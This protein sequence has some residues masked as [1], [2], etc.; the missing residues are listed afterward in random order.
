MHEGTFII[1]IQRTY[2]AA[3][4]A[5]FTLLAISFPLYV[6]VVLAL[7]QSTFETNSMHRK[8][9]LFRHCQGLLLFR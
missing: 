7:S 6:R 2:K 1:P 4:I 8:A 9:V 3:A 5:N